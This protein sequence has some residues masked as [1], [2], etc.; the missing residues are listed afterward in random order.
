MKIIVK[1]YKY[2]SKRKEKF[3]VSSRLWELAVLGQELKETGKSMGGVGWG[4]PVDKVPAPSHT[5]AGHSLEM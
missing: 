4:K 3:L 1:S 2:F 5:A